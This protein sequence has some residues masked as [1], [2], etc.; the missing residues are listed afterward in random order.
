M[1][2]A[3]SAEAPDA[4]QG[5]DRMAKDIAGTMRGALTHIVQDLTPRLQTA[6]K[7]K[8]SGS[9]LVPGIAVGAGLGVLAPL[10]VKGAGRLAKRQLVAGVHR[11]AERPGEALS[12]VTSK[13]DGAVGTGVG[14]KGKQAVAQSGGV[15]GVA[16]KLGQVGK[17]VLPSTSN[18]GQG[19]VPGVGKGR[20]MPVQ[21]TMD[22]GVPLSTCYNQWT[23]FGEWPTFMHRVTRVTQEEPTTVGFTAKIWAVSKEFKAVIE[24]QRPDELIRWRVADGLMHTGVVTFHEITPRLTRVEMT[25]D[26]EPGSLVE[27]A[28]RGMRHIKRAMRADMHRFKAYIEMRGTES[29]AWR[30]VIEDGE[31]VEDPDPGSGA[32][33]QQE[34]LPAAAGDTSPPETATETPSEAGGDSRPHAAQ[35]RVRAAQDAGGGDAP[36][37]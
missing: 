19:G 16:D 14:E 4:N 21:Q 29:G 33:P 10:A 8:P 36:G 31:L 13:L 20:R 1:P 5:D 3:L 12:T 32:D 25:V 37:Q 15:H 7:S 24:T 11:V 35:A 26:V 30:G 17:G 6:K 2:P 28:A 22:V 34:A 23:Q 18:A 9:R 27:K